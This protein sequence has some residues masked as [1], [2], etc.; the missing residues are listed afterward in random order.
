MKKIIVT[1]ALGLFSVAGFGYSNSKCLTWEGTKDFPVISDRKVHR[2]PA[3]NLKF[4]LELTIYKEGWNPNG[5][6]IDA[7]DS[8]YTF[9]DETLMKFNPQGVQVGEK[10][11]KKEQGPGDFRSKDPFFSN[12]GLL[13]IADSM[14]RRITCL[15]D[16]YEV[17]KIHSL[18]F[19]FDIFC[20]DSKDN[21]YLLVGNFL[22][23]TRDKIKF[24]L[25]KFSPSGNLLY[26][27]TDYET[28]PKR[29]TQGIIHQ[30]FY[31]PQLRYKLDSQDN[32]YYA[33]TNKYEIHIVSAEGKPIKAIQKK[34][35][36]RSITKQEIV[37]YL[38]KNSP[39]GRVVTDIPEAMPALA[40]IFVLE[41]GSLL[42]VTFD[43][44]D[45]EPTL[46]GDLFD[47]EGRY[48]ARIQVPKYHSWYWLFMSAKS[49][50]LIKKN[51]FYTIESDP[52]EIKFY[53][54]RYRIISE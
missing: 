33:M 19:F 14:Q 8:I 20:L 17:V 54:R 25:S 5:L 11:F 35:N 24:V 47:P 40:D 28:G 22:P 50:A 42:V 2:G 52:D 15:N 16:K 18:K 29:D 6:F 49:N 27:I 9:S 4:E 3:I 53:I 37:K 43:N 12:Q 23:K 32:V 1:L 51:K 36:P 39:S 45:A 13:Y 34:A 38:P 26:E 31:G 30:S 21:W 46:A 7:D 10:S 41:N 44:D 48:R